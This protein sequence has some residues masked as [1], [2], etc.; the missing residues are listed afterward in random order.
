MAKAELKEGL[1]AKAVPAV[2]E[3]RREASKAD[4]DHFSFHSCYSEWPDWVI[5]CKWRLFQ[6]MFFFSYFYLFRPQLFDRF[7]L[8]DV[9]FL[10]L[11]ALN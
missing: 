1:R 2:V 3:K 6:V 7:P 4:V 10:A 11:L 5:K 8:V 9:D